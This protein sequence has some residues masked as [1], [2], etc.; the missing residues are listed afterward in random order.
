MAYHELLYLARSTHL[1]KI[2]FY[3]CY[4][5]MQSLYLQLTFVHFFHFKSYV[6]HLCYNLNWTL[7]TSNI[8]K[9]LQKPCLDQ[10]VH[11]RYKCTGICTA[12]TIFL[13]L[14]LKA[15]YKVCILIRLI[16][17]VNW[18]HAFFKTDSCKGARLHFTG[19]RRHFLLL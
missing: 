12:W 3:F 11:A 4:I 14:Y 1:K 17:E 18:H 9:L 13:P 19:Y 10:N 15:M 2:F 8:L 16:N 7:S 6:S 5:T